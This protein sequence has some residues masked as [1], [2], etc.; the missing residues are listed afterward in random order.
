VSAAACAI[1][2]SMN[3]YVG[4]ALKKS[5]EEY[6]DFVTEFKSSLQDLP[7]IN[8]MEFLGLTAG[9][10]TDVY[11]VDLGN[12]RDCDAMIAMIDEPSIGLGMEIQYATSLKKQLLCLNRTGNDVTRMVIGASELGL[13]NL[14][15]YDDEEDALV[16]AASFLQSVHSAG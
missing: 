10:A 3:V 16:R 8:V 14:E 9:T 13:L 7:D 11:T 6:R 2:F 12:V 1:L 4:C 5:S 15:T